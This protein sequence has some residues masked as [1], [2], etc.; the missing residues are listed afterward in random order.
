MSL[1]SVDRSANLRYSGAEMAAAGVNRAIPVAPVN[2]TERVE[3]RPPVEAKAPTPSVINLV[4]MANKPG[5]GEAV[6]VGTPD[7]LRRGSEAATSPK[8]WTINRPE[9][10]KEKIPPP[11]PLSKILMDFLHNMWRASGTAVKESLPEHLRTTD[12]V[13]QNPL[14]A[15]GNIAKEVLTYSPTKVAKTEKSF[16]GD[17]NPD[18]TRR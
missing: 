4:N 13:P 7:S 15:P 8:D 5:D 12:D 11:E 1:P 2:P 16:S 9:P 3:V 14:S 18:S 17:A 6:N 10:V